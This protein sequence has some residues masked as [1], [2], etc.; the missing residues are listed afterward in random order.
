M[1]AAKP[2]QATPVLRNLSDAEKPAGGLHVKFLSNQFA[3]G[4][5]S[6]K[7]SC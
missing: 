1:A 5:S 2:G 7:L 6:P 4:L 3:L